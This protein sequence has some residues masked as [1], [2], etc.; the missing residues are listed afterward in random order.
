MNLTY[1][2]DP[3]TFSVNIFAEGRNEP[4]VYQP[5]WPNST[6]W[7]S[8]SEASLWAQLCIQAITDNDAPHAPA[9]PGMSGEQKVLPPPS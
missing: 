7:A 6:P 8:S 9:G 5:D 2:V 1:V 4:I 3:V